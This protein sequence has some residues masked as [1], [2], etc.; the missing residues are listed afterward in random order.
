MENIGQRQLS[1]FDEK[2][3]DLK[4]IK[5]CWSNLDKM[6]L[7]IRDQKIMVKYHWKDVVYLG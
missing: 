4:W 7:T 6:I 1:K 5:R 3:F 2:V